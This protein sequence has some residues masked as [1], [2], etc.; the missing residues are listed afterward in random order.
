[1]NILFNLIK[2]SKFFINP[3]TKNNQRKDNHLLTTLPA[4]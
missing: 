3:K 2:L 1:M 4:E